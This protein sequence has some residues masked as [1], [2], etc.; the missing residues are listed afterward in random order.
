MRRIGREGARVGLAALAAAT[1]FAAAPLAVATTPPTSKPGA[2]THSGEDD[3]SEPRR[4]PGRPEHTNRLI[5]SSSQYLLQ[6]AHNPVDWWPW[7][8]EAFAAA[9]AEG[10]PIFLSVGYSTCY[11]CHVMERRVFENEEIAAQMNMGFICIKVDREQRPDLDEIYMLPTQLL[12]R[13]GGWPNSVFLTHELK[14][15]YAG[16]YFGPVDEHGRPGFPRVL[17]AMRDAWENQQEAVQS[18]AEQLTAAMREMLAAGLAPLDHLPDGAAA[19]EAAIG[20]LAESFDPQEG[21][22]GM[23]PKFPQGFMFPF[24][25]SAQGPMADEARRMAVRTLERMAL[26]GMYDQIGGGF[27]RYSTDA[28]WRVPHFEKMLYDQASLVQAYAEAH[29]VTGNPEFRRIAEETTRFVASSL[30]GDRGE[31]YSALDA[32]TD[33]VEG[34]YYLW[35]EEQIRE[36]LAPEQAGLFFSV[37]A[38][39][40]V[41]HIP[42]HGAPEGG[43]VYALRPF[44]ESVRE[45]ALTE[46]ALL[47][48]LDPIRK[49]LLAER[50]RRKAPLL[51]TKV[52]C[53]WNG[54]M[55]EGC[56][57]AAERLADPATLRQ[58]EQA[59]AFALDE[60]LRED[61]RLWR[62]WRNGKGEISGFLEDYAHLALGLSTLA[63]VSNPVNGGGA[64]GRWA[65][66][67]AGLLDTADRLF[68][69]EETG[70]YYSSEPAPDVIVRTKNATDGATPSGVSAAAHALLNLYEI[71][72]EERF[73]QRCDALLRGVGGVVE[74]APT[75]ALSLTH[76]AARRS[77]LGQPQAPPQ[78]APDFIDRLGPRWQPDASGAGDAIIEAE[79]FA[80]VSAVRPGDEFAIA[81]RLTISRGWHINANPATH[82]TLIPTVVSVRSAAPIETL[83]VEYPAGEEAALAFGEGPI[84]VYTAE[85]VFVARLR[86]PK[87]RPAGE[88][89]DLR[90]LYRAQPC[91]EDACLAP[92]EGA[93]TIRLPVQAAGSFVEPR[94]ADVFAPRQR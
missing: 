82:E 89:V 87:Q 73:L 4:E 38:L 21:G 58:A 56:A 76:A 50:S 93:A 3:M 75:A 46:A 86:L 37:Y 80:S 2:E 55:I 54:M 24:L 34:Q 39:G 63:R 43:V 27:H 60:L 7:G 1:C 31:F 84:R 47:E 51:D 67:A 81:L 49:R 79:A 22:F 16:T 77:R 26:G 91:T 57:A 68:G 94:H 90:V 72:S 70:A 40:P 32:E 29:A 65:T 66:A 74:R 83:G 6:H 48:G 78:R 23:A 71:S 44:A 9:K 17:A 30:T 10:K 92:L 20:E 42:G 64:G 41:P 62:T 59:A 88:D 19:E 85:V 28:Q 11:W 52:I 25:L 33:A 61:G 14:P 12:T 13:H 36:A 69:D 8:E 18:Q 53:S 15:F 5:H 45:L 35:T